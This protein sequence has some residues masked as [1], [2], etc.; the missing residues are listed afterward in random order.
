MSV[1]VRIKLRTVKLGLNLPSLSDFCPKMI[2]NQALRHSDFYEELIAQVLIFH[3]FYSVTTQHCSLSC[4]NC[5]EPLFSNL[6][7]GMLLKVRGIGSTVKN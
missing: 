1:Q 5:L 6:R 2:E 3:L 7:F 4:M